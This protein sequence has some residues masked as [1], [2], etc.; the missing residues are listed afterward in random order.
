MRDKKTRRQ[1]LMSSGAAMIVG[2][3]GCQSPKQRYNEQFREKELTANEFYDSM[4][5]ENGYLRVKTTTDNPRIAQGI[6]EQCTI[7]TDDGAKVD[8]VE[9]APTQTTYKLDFNGNGEYRVVTYSD[10]TLANVSTGYYV[11][12]VMIA[13]IKIENGEVEIDEHRRQFITNDDG[14]Q[15]PR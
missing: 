14:P 10:S 3:A 12:I 8:R 15:V 9:L 4:S 2:L 5:I 7:L 6:F 11:G 13:E 1:L